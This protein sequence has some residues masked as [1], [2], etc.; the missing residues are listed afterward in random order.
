MFERLDGI[1][2]RA[3]ALVCTVVLSGC[4]GGES[5]D[6]GFTGPTGSPTT[7]AM[8][9]PN[10]SG[11]TTG[12]PTTGA[13]V[14]TSSG[15]GESSG[16]PLTAG[17]TE[18][19]SSS[20][21]SSTGEPCPLG[22]EGCPCNIDV[23]DG[24]LVCEADVC[25][26]YM[27]ACGNGKVDPLEECDDGN[28]VETDDCLTGCIAAKCGDGQVQARVE[29]CDDGNVVD[30][31]GCTAMCALE[32][33][34]N[35]KLDGM[36]ECDDGN[37][38]D[39]DACLSTCLD[40]S[41]GDGAVQAGVETC[42]DGNQDE[43]DACLNTCKPAS[44]GDGKVQAGVE[45]CDDGNKVDTDAC[46]G[47]C[48]KAVCGDKF[49]QSMVEECDDGNQNAG[50]GCTAMCLNECGNDCWGNAGCKTNGGKCI[51]F[52]CT[53]GNSSKTACDTCFGWKQVTYDQWMNQGYCA[54]VT[55]K[56]RS[57]HNNETR[58]GA[59]PVCCSTPGAC[60]GGDN[61]WHFHD[62]NNNRYVGPC[63][64]CN[65]D[66]NCQFWNGTDDGTY[67]RITACERK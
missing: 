22:S 3:S 30:G 59:A 51:R 20:S 41:C 58:C 67:T 15:S 40:A 29:A 28:D 44:C 42:D 18:D 24:E 53:P 9:E 36:E 31:D 4:G 66:M 57:I 38:V 27:P 19:P 32:S 16:G 47:V 12:A 63:L 5:S 10:T 2:V 25:V 8:T 60:G 50:D 65:N 17:T 34:G 49:V 55:T 35:G 61:A 26:V 6:T 21:S 64:G 39:T 43:T 23:C 45:E 54:D 14:T 46:V 11:G 56:Y 1:W 48:K 33:C 13:P 37:K 62:G 52:T 7:V